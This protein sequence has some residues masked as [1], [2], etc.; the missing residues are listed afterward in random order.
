MH[1]VQVK[2]CMGQPLCVDVVQP[3]YSHKRQEIKT[4]LDIFIL[5]SIKVYLQI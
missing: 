2:M 5:F 4:N 1:V 3:I